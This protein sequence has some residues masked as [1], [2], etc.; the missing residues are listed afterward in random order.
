[1]VISQNRPGA[2]FSKAPEAYRARKAIFTYLYLENRDVYRPEI[3]YEGNTDHIKNIMGSNSSVI[4]K[5]E[6]LLSLPGAKTFRDLRE[7]GPCNVFIF[8][9]DVVIVT[10]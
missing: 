1:M 2:C 3:L 5:F 10:R 9:V 4:I 8:V 6:I 7:T